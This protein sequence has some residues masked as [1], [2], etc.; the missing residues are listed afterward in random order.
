MASG[1]EDDAADARDVLNGILEQHKVHHGVDFVVFVKRVD[2]RLREHS[3]V[4]HLVVQHLV[5]RLR[6]VAKDQRVGILG[7]EEARH[8]GRGE[9]LLGG[10]GGEVAVLGQVGGVD[11]AVPV[12]A[13]RFVEP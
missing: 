13:L 7:G 6:V 3:Q 4:C 5:H 2:G 8:V 1:V 9:V 10:L 11:E 12:H